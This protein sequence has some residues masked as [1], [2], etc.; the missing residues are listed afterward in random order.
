MGIRQTGA[1]S[2]NLVLRSGRSRTSRDNVKQIE[3]AR[4]YHIQSATAY[5]SEVLLGEVEVDILEV[6]VSHKRDNGIECHL[7]Q[8][9][10]LANLWR[11]WRRQETR[12]SRREHAIH[13]VFQSG[14]S[15]NCNRLDTNVASISALY[16]GRRS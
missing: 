10:A 1:V 11:M 12:R 14:C 5:S 9:E 7:R 8:V 2:C 3:V 16:Y 15:A 4:S 13:L 6:C